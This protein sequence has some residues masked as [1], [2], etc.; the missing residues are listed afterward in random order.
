MNKN[1]KEDY[2]EIELDLPFDIYF[3]LNE[4]ARKRGLLLNDYINNILRNYIDNQL[5]QNKK[6]K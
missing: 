1:N 6:A 3:K 5:K 4:Q 2:T